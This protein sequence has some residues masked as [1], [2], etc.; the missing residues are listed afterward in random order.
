MTVKVQ[1]IDRAIRILKLFSE[2]RKELKLTEISEELDLNKSTVHGIISTLRYH[3]LI[4]QDEETQKYRLGLYLMEL[5]ERVAN[6]MDI[7]Q[8]SHPIID[9]LC[10]T[11]EETVHLAALEGKEVVYIDKKESNQSIRIISAIGARN[12][13]YCT[14]VGKAMLAFKDVDEIYE[15]LPDELVQL[16]P[17]TITDKEELLRE[18]EEIRLQGYALD[19]E[20]N[21]AG[22]T[23]VAAPIFDSTGKAVY[24]ISVSGPTMRMNYK[25]IEKAREIVM[26]S[27]KKISKELGYKF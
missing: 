9:E 26:E 10:T 11:M 4:D 16:T 24:A 19:N 25:Q 13:A 27:T 2:E 15:S 7:I 3:R 20:E 18:L 17:N 21:S 1:A 8:I 22:L 12:P 14:G 6:S 5:G 23:C